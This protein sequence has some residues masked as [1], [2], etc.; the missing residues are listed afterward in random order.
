MLASTVRSFACAQDDG[1][2]ALAEPQSKPRIESAL[3][4]FATT[5]LRQGYGGQ[6]GATLRQSFQSEAGIKRAAVVFA[7]AR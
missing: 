3:I 7:T 2:G 5:R 1:S 4:M 6:A